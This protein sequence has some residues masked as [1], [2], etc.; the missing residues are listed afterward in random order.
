MPTDLKELARVIRPKGE[1]VLGFGSAKALRESG[2]EDRGFSLYDVD[3]VIDACEQSGFT[4][5]NIDKIE[6]GR[7]GDFY[8]YRGIKPA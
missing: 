5:D 8:A 6:R 3:E 4:T 7:R 2:Y 1:L